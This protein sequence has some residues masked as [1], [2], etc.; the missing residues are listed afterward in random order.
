MGSLSGKPNGALA[1][2]DGLLSGHEDAGAYEPPISIREPYPGGPPGL[3][4]KAPLQLELFGPVPFR[5]T[6]SAVVPRPAAAERVAQL[7]EG[8]LSQ[9]E[10]EMYVTIGVTETKEGIRVISSSEPR[11]KRQVLDL[12]QEGEIPVNGDGHAEA[13]GVRGALSYGLTPTGVAVSR[14]ICDN[15]A[16][17]LDEQGISALTPLK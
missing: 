15:C 11:L 1:P 3:L 4:G 6:L 13:N 16:R 7:A 8:G 10:R 2:D 14:P 5:Q 9:I 17:Y 12:L